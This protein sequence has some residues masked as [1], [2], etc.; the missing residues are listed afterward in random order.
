MQVG[1][2]RG[3]GDG[4]TLMFNGHLDVVPPGD[5]ATW[6]DDPFF[7]ISYHVRHVR[8]PDPTNDRIVYTGVRTD[9][10]M[11]AKYDDGEE[12]LYDLQADP[13]ELQNQQANPQYAG[14]L[15]AL[16]T[17]TEQLKTCRG[18]NCGRPVPAI[19]SARDPR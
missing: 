19:V 3:T 16:A 9:R 8:N 14:V 6:S 2:W 5:P 4:K 7:D 11:Y 18:T 15:A 13:F 17:L 10:Y 1:T 12:E